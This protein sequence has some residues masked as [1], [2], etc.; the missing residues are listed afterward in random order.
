[1][2][3]GNINDTQ[4]AMAQPNATTGENSIVIRPTMTQGVVHGVDLSAA[5]YALLVKL[6]NS[7]DSTHFSDSLVHVQGQE[8]HSALSNQHSARAAV[9]CCFDRH[10]SQLGYSGFQDANGL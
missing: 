2:P 5:D 1:M 4:A 9:W 6:E 10:R 8:Q 3:S 7:A